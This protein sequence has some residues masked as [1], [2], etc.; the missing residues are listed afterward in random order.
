MVE[1]VHPSLESPAL[2]CQSASFFFYFQ[3]FEISSFFSFHRHR[4]NL[5]ASFSKGLSCQLQPYF[6]MGIAEMSLVLHE[7][8]SNSCFTLIPGSS[9]K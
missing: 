9:P 5:R 2:T 1:K 6:V 8:L 7:I 4:V 3:T